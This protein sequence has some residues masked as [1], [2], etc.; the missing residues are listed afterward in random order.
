[1]LRTRDVVRDLGLDVLE[2]LEVGASLL[3]PARPADR[4][5]QQLVEAL[6][7]PGVFVVSQSRVEDPP[8]P[9]LPHPGVWLIPALLRTYHQH[10]NVL[11]QLIVDIRLVN[12]L[13]TLDAL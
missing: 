3:L 4:L 12:T 10:A 9:L 13:E 8:L 6:G 2:R 11:A 5:R 1:P 7:L